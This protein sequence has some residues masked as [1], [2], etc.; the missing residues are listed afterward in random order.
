MPNESQNNVVEYDGVELP[1]FVLDILSL[2]PKHSMRDR[3]DEVHL[4]ANE[5][6]LVRE[7]RDNNTDR[8]R[9]REIELSVKWYSEILSENQ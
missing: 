8:E 3:S 7:F 1:K 4:L 6:R 2:G 5:D 9:L